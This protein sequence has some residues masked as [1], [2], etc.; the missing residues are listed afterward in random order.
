LS[1]SLIP[2]RL[3][4][5]ELSEALENVIKITTATGIA[6]YKEFVNIEKKMLSPKLQLTIYRIVQEQFANILKHARAQHIYLSITN[7]NNVVQMSIKDD[8]QGFDPRIKSKGVGL[9]NIRARASLFDSKVTIRSA[10]GKG[11]E[12]KI[13]FN[14]PKGIQQSGE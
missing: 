6:V 7:Q 8:G 5:S 13:N 10:V 2:P 4:E 11:C 3:P 14:Q 12:L 1:H 9:M